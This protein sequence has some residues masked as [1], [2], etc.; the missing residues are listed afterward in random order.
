MQIFDPDH[1]LVVNGTHD[2]EGY[3]PNERRAQQRKEQTPMAT[4]K[5]ASR[6]DRKLSAPD[7]P[8]RGRPRKVPL[9]GLEDTRIGS[10]DDICASVSE[11]REQLNTLRAEEAGQ[12]RTALGL[13]RKHEKTT[14]RAAGVELARVP[15]EE[16]L[17]VRTTKEP[18]TAEVEDD[19]QVEVTDETVDATQ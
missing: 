18:A 4:R 3:T 5:A 17:R 7:A 1:P 6:I 15:G 14:W 8:R 10:L 9:P 16:K 2:T 13:M 19:E 12:L 11:I